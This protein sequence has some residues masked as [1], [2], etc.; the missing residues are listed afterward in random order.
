MLR[1]RWILALTAAVAVAV[2]VA[3]ARPPTGKCRSARGNV[4]AVNRLVVAYEL[5]R[6]DSTPGNDAISG[7]LIGC[8]R[9]SGNKVQLSGSTFGEYWFDRPARAVK[10]RGTTIGF[11][12]VVD[13]GYG[14]SFATQISFVDMR[15]PQSTVAVS[16]SGL[17]GSLDFAIAPARAGAGL[18]ARRSAAWIRCPELDEKMNADPRPNCVRA[19][20]SDNA[21][22]AVAA[23]STT[24]VQLASHRSID[25]LSVRVRDGRVSW[26]Q[27]AERRSAP[28]PR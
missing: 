25:P 22:F 21:V 6:P 27:G 12:A 24:P 9:A 4:I 1:A 16:A 14:S 28:M 8:R 17:I 20:R 5:G 10:V 13:P 26:L 18:V 7:R 11:A 19:G 3:E 2:S 15:R 23:G